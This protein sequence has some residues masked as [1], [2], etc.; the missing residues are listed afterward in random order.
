MG[1]NVT[2]HILLCIELFSSAKIECVKPSI[3]CGTEA[4]IKSGALLPPNGFCAEVQIVF[5][6]FIGVIFSIHS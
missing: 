5:D 3:L 2:D 6:G 4:R 1:G